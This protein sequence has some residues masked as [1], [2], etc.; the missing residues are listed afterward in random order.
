MT[1][2]T[3]TRRASL[4]KK[5]NFPFGTI[6]AMLTAIAVIFTGVIAGADSQTI[7]GRTAVSSLL[8]GLLVAL[9]VSVIRFV[10]REAN[11]RDEAT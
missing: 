4:R 9:G 3:E 10:N 6:T 8:M 5:R 1:Q 11:R 2:R 7:L